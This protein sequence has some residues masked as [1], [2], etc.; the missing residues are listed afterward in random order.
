[1]LTSYPGDHLGGQAIIVEMT[2]M[3]YVVL[4]R[5]SNGDGRPRTIRIDV[6][7]LR[8]FVRH[9]SEEDHWFGAG[10]MDFTWPQEQALIKQGWARR[11]FSGGL[12]AT[13]ALTSALA[14]MDE[15]SK[16]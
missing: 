2:P 8:R 10:W 12:Y 3:P 16:R 14:E 7:D 4:E 15:R 5:G 9:G 6:A 1:M 11:G 13:E